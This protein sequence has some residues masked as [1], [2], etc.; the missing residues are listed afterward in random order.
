MSLRR[1]M[2]SCL[3]VEVPT[4]IEYSTTTHERAAVSRWKRSFG[5]SHTSPIPKFG[6][7][8]RWY[9][10]K[11]QTLRIELGDTRRRPLAEQSNAH[12]DK[13]EGTFGELGVWGCSID[14]GCVGWSAYQKIELYTRPESELEVLTYVWA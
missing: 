4:W 13:R 8:V 2:A 1:L 9:L 14:D 7:S 3:P 10:N 5:T 6:L 11:Q 12:L